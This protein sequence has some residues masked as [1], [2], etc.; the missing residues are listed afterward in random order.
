MGEEAALRDAELARELRE[1][2]AR[3]PIARG[4]AKGRVEDLF[5]RLR[6]LSHPAQIRPVVLFVKARN[7][8]VDVTR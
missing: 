8:D 1:A 4:E 2:Q 3:K 6:S 7:V 5:A